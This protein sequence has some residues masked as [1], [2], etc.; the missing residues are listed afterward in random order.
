ME[1]HKVTLFIAQR[2]TVAG[3]VKY[4]EQSGGAKAKIMGPSV[5]SI[6][7]WAEGKPSDTRLVLPWRIF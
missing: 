1:I 7:E 6:E 3:T 2:D 4:N 5:R